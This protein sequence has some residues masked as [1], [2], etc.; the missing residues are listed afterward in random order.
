[1]LI[2]NVIVPS[3]LYFISGFIEILDSNVSGLGKKEH[4]SSFSFIL[5]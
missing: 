5:T 3:G 1:M 4:D 2:F